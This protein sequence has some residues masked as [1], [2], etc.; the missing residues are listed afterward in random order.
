MASLSSDKKGNRTI[1]FKDG[2]KRKSI[3]LG[4]MSKRQADKIKWHVEALLT[5]RVTGQLEVDTAQ[6]LA[7]IDQWLHDRLANVGLIKAMS[8]KLGD[9][10]AECIERK[11]GAVKEST[12]TRQKQAERL[13]LEHFAHDKRLSEFTEGDAEDFRN[14]LIKTKGMAEATVRKRCADARM[15]FTYARKHRMLHDNPFD[16]VPTANVATQH[17]DFIKADDAQKIMD[18]LPSAEWRL[19]F[20]LARW[21]GLRIPSE[22]TL[23]TWGDVDWENQRLTIHSPKTEHLPGHETRQLPIFPEIAGPL[24][25]V[26]DNANEGALNVLPMVVGKVGGAIRKPLLRAIKAAGM[27]SWPR[28]WHNLRST[29]QTELEDSFP[30]HVV[31]AW[32]GNNRDTARRHYLQVTDN[33][34]T[35]AVHNPVQQAP[36]ST[37]KDAQKQGTNRKEMRET[38]LSGNQVAP[39]GLE[40]TRPLRSTDFKSVASANS[41]TGPGSLNPCFSA[42]TG[43]L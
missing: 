29:R 8:G 9:F 22:P 1:Q 21:G 13:L 23:L 17:H 42:L 32:L 5:N 40:P 43:I 28:L 20:A 11:R 26:F 12:I 10:I 37:D 36:A 14:W 15:F 19:L 33:H 6:W 25:E 35:L 3:R 2:L 27:E 34:F 24:Q 41:A 39:V 4:K 18:K 30:S 31:C 7:G 38:A 16:I